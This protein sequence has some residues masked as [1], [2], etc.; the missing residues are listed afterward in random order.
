MAEVGRDR[1]AEDHQLD[2]RR[3]QQHPGQTRVAEDLQELLA[4]HPDDPRRGTSSAAPCGS[5][6]LK[7]RM[8][9]AQADDGV[10]HHQERLRPTGT[11]RPTSLRKM[12]RVT[13]RK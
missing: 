8:A 7:E 12:P 3:H 2:H 6:F 1:V 13:T 9:S 5:S 11:S 10:D 4:H